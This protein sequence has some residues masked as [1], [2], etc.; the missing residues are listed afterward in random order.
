MGAIGA[1]GN[2]PWVITVGAS[3]TMGTASRSD[4]TMASF[5]S[6]G[7]T[8][9]DW[10]AKPDLVAPGE[11]SV[12]TLSAGSTLAT[13]RP[14]AVLPGADGTPEYLSLSGT[15]MATPVVSGVV[16]LMLQANPKLTPNAVKAI[17]QYTAQEYPGYK[18]LEQGAGFLNAVGAVQ[19]CALLRDRAA[20]VLRSRDQKMWSGD[21]LWGNH[22]LT[23]GI[24]NPVR[25]RLR[26]WH[27]LGRRGDRRRRQHR[28]G[29]GRRR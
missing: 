9:L 7:P 3:S 15:S 18:P 19:P 26:G 8:F 21:L 12:S 22:S 28:V 16:A 24:L 4:D 17:L 5:S 27:D 13:E 29:H 11:G 23:G 14:T 20:L 6:R 2:A 10:A 1:P 25:E